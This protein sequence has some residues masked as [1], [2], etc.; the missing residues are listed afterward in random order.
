MKTSNV[1]RCDFRIHDLID[2]KFRVERILGESVSDRK[3]KV[4]DSQGRAYIL[5]LLK[6]WEV[7][8][9]MQ[10]LMSARSESEIKS[11]QIKSNYLTPIVYTGTVKG[12]PYLLTEYCQS[13]NLSKEIHSPKLDLLLTLKQILYGLRDLHKSGK[14]HGHLTPENILI[15]ESGKTILTNYITLGDRCKALSSYHKTLRS[16]MLDKSCAYLPPEFYRLERCTT[17]LPTADIFSFGVILYQLLTG[18]LPFGRLLTESDWIHYQSC[19]RTGDWNK[20]TLQRG[21]LRETWIKII[22]AC[23]QPNAFLR[24]PRVDDVLAMLPDTTNLYEA[25]E[26][27][28]IEASSTI[29][30]GLLLR[31]MQGDEFG[32]LYR[33]PEHLNGPKRIVTLGRESN[34]VFNTLVIK[35]K[36][37]TYI[38]RKHCTLEWDDEQDI[39]YIRDGQWDKES[40]E[41]WTRSLNG[42][43]VNSEEIGV[44][45]RPLVPGDILSIGDTKLRV[46]GY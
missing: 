23:L 43:Y 26:P 1:Q 13:I 19:V 34:S 18:A 5:K 6:L 42:T 12:N 14:V 2:G 9:Q 28:Q 8:P 25:I 7:D 40:N 37:S 38:S 46:E 15:T 10:Q 11:C 33:L 17:V 20:N 3:F 44:E 27:N 41:K 21:E 16:N 32:R 35:E 36:T 39:W 24:A 29:L 22:D 31:V 45:G 4:A 30:N